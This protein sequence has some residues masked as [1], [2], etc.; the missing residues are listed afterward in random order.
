MLGQ[1]I[2]KFQKIFK[3][4]NF[5]S[6]IQKSKHNI[7]QINTL[8]RFIINYSLVQYIQ[9][10]LFLTNI[11]DQVIFSTNDIIQS[12]FR[13]KRCQTLNQRSTNEL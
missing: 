13:Y 9:Y 3:K 4:I 10:S 6:I 7:Y 11:P 12:E 5:Q 2:H 8:S 1:H